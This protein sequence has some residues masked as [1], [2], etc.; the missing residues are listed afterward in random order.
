[1]PTFERSQEIREQIKK[2]IDAGM[3]TPA[4]I[5]G[6]IGKDAPS[7]ATISRIMREEMGYVKIETEWKKGK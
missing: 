6:W 3:E 7:L 5:A 2:A 1:M 4:Q